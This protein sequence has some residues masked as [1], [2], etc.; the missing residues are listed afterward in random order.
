VRK[1]QKKEKTAHPTDVRA[2]HLAGVRALAT[3]IRAPRKRARPL[4]V[5]VHAP[6]DVRAPHL[7][8]VRALRAQACAPLAVIRAPLTCAPTTW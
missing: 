7:A 6:L 3:W 2:S 8:G 4:L 5:G 1:T